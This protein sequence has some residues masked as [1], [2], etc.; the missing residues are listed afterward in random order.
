M[1]KQ[2]IIQMEL[3]KTQDIHEGIIT[4][5]KQEQIKELLTELILAVWEM[6]KRKEG[7]NE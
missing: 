1:R 5:S 7:E 6:N 2:Y 3:F 4:K